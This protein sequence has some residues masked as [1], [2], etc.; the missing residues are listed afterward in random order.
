MTTN[1]Q[2]GP[3]TPTDIHASG[4]AARPTW[5]R[6]TIYKAMYRMAKDGVL[7]REGNGFVLCAG[8]K[9]K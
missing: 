8:S 4:A 1:D 9:T 2:G 6:Q 3:R 7:I 5:S